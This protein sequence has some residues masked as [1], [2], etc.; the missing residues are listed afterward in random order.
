[1]V[2]VSL[3][4]PGTAITGGSRTSEGAEIPL[5]SLIRSSYL[6]PD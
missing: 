2:Q 6:E 4:R 5:G 1:M 3:R